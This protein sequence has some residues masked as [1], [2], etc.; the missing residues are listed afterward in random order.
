[1]F[2]IKRF[3]EQFKI[4]WMQ[5]SQRIFLNMGIFALIIIFSNYMIFNHYMDTFNFEFWGF[6]IAFMTFISSANIF[7]SLQ[8]TS[9]GIHY[10]MT[11]ATITEKYAAAWI[12]SSFFT[13]IV[14]SIT[15]LLVH[16]VCVSI[17]NAFTDL[18]QVIHLPSSEKLWMGFLG[19]LFYH[20]FFILGATIFKKN[21]FLKTVLCI[22]LLFMVI[23]AISTSILTWYMGGIE[24]MNSYQWDIEL[25]DWSDFEKLDLL[26]FDVETLVNILKMTLISIPVI[27]WITAYFKLKTRQI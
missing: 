4:I 25:N 1:M 11:P 10:Y 12:Y 6:I 14:Y 13:I 17:G 27:L 26:M 7:S 8:Q 20:S 9:S 24:G 5:N 22:I 21:P 16:F 19:I 2:S 23:G 3:F 15:V 18:N